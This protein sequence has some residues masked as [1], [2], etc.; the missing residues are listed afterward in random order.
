M[1]KLSCVVVPEDFTLLD[2]KIRE[3]GPTCIEIGE[4]NSLNEKDPF[5]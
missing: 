2:Y 3:V 4:K 5:P 1:H